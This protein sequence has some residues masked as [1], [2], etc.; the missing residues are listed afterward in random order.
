VF[1]MDARKGEYFGLDPSFTDSWH[2]LTKGE[3]S[4]DERVSKL[5]RAIR[6]R[7]WITDHRPSQY[8]AKEVR[9]IPQRRSRSSSFRAYLCLVRAFGSLRFLGFRQAYEWAQSVDATSVGALG[10]KNRL[11]VLRDALAAFS[12]GEHF[13]ISRL[14]LDD[15]LPRSLALFVFLRAAGFSVCHCIGIRRHPF[16]AHAWVEHDAIPLLSLPDSIVDF[17]KIATIGPNR[18]TAS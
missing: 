1:V 13:V 7:G 17:T 4:S 12:R 2:R 3:E 8:P 16:I 6:A 9:C 14:R 5:A 11:P 18:L 15:C 10:M